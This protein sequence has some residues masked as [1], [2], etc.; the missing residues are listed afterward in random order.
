M[1]DVGTEC[2]V[3]TF[4][5]SD[6]FSFLDVSRTNAG[7]IVLQTAT[8]R[9]SKKIRYEQSRWNTRHPPM[10]GSEGGGE[11]GFG[12]DPPSSQGPLWPPPKAGRNF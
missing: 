4:W 7:S 2:D 9:V 11:G 10:G 12:W 1:L 3:S 8:A 5:L 6:W